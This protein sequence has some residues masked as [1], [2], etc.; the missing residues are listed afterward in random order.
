MLDDHLGGFDHTLKN[1]VLDQIPPGSTCYT[2]YILPSQVRKQYPQLNLKFSAW[3]ALTGNHVFTVV[4]EVN[5]NSNLV[6]PN[7]KNFLCSFNRSDQ[8][9]RHWLIAALHQLGWFN[10]QY[11]S[12]HFKINPESVE[13]CDWIDQPKSFRRKK[14]YDEIIGFDFESSWDHRTNLQVLSPLIQD[15][16]VTLASES[17]AAGTSVPFWTE[18]FL[19]PVANQRLW[20]SYASP[21]YHRFLHTYFGF[22]PYTCFD[23]RFDYIKDPVI[24]LQTLLQS[25]EPFAEMTNQQ[26][27]KIYQDQWPIIQWNYEWLRSGQCINHLLLFDQFSEMIPDQ[28]VWEQYFLCPFSDNDLYQR[29]YDQFHTVKLAQQQIQMDFATW[30]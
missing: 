25:L 10:P 22:R 7:F 29:A 8:L 16:F 21:G 11:C 4:D 23:Y 18:K 30:P 14:F 9:G 15:N 2:E 26:W 19:Y 27:Q 5:K 20:L 17:F 28:S 1:S 13:L 12:K 24:R 3:L 6:T